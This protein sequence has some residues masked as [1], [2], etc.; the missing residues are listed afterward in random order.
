MFFADSDHAVKENGFC[1][2]RF[3]DDLMASKEFEARTSHD[4]VHEHLRECQSSLHRWGKANRA[5]F[6]AGKE[7]FKIIHHIMPDGDPFKYLGVVFDCKLTMADEVSRIEKKA[8]AKVTAILRSQHFYNTVELV[9]QYN[10][11][12]LCILEGSVGA[13]YDASP[14]HLLKLDKIQKKF[15]DGIGLGTANKLS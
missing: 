10:T 7:H 3:A 13:I 9:Q 1:G 5:L 12:I 4:L 2:T 11:Q 15:L 6:D 14:T 8:R